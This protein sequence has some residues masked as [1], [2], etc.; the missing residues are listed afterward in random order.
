MSAKKIEKCPVCSKKYIIDSEEY[1]WHIKIHLAKIEIQ[2]Y[3][4]QPPTNPFPYNNDPIVA[5]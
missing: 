1:Y 2:P 3:Q 5:C 4:T